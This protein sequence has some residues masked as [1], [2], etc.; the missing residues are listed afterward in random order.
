MSFAVSVIIFAE[1]KSIETTDAGKFPF[2][3]ATVILENPAEGGPE[4]GLGVGLNAGVKVG[5]GKGVGEKVGDGEGAAVKEGIGLGFSVGEAGGTGCG[6]NFEIIWGFITTMIIANKS[7]A[8][9]KGR[10]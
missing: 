2:S 7:A 4:T 10:R 3:V 1:F 9:I 5:R 8:I 6:F